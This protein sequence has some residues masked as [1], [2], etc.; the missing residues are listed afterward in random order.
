MKASNLSRKKMMWTMGLFLSSVYPLQYSMLG[1]DKQQKEDIKERGS[2]EVVGVADPA[3]PT[4]DR[5]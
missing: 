2:S 4:V 3:K 1:C 5:R